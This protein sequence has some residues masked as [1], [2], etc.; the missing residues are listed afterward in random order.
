MT[1]DRTLEMPTM[2]HVQTT[3]VQ[4]SRC[5]RQSARA[6][7]ASN[8]RKTRLPGARWRAGAIAALSACTL[9]A[10]GGGGGGTPGNQPSTAT[11]STPA[12]KPQAALSAA[13]SVKVAM[14]G[15]STVTG[16]TLQA[17]APAE[18]GCLA[19]YTVSPH[20]EP[21]SLQFA[22][23]QAYGTGVT[24]ENHGIPGS[25]CPQWLWGQGGV[26][27]SWA[28]E[29][30]N[31]DAQIVTMNCAINDAFLPNETDQDFQFVY[32]QFAQIARQYGKT[33]VIM[34]PNPINDPH[35]INLGSLV[36]D[37]QYVAR[38]QGVAIVDQWSTIQTTMPNWAAYLPDNI[39]PNDALYE[40]KAQTSLL[41]LDPLVRAL[42][43]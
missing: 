5:R 10:C 9:S 23:Q 38:A 8:H 2:N 14:Y 21:T 37:E 27:N 30:A 13:K 39:H 11:Q 3:T 18:S 32:G 19:G 4:A 12:S 7:A 42:I 35:N 22:L 41:T 31:S 16:C 1:H 24:V 43:Q 36:H 28:V 26:K 34:T 29:M 6:P 25:T 17:G 40:Y 20:N 15:D 33:F